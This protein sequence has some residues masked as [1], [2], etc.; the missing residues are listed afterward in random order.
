M[1]GT[2]VSR[3]R[4]P[5]A[6]RPLRLFSDDRLARM[7]A[8]G[9][10]RAVAALYERHHRA[11]FRYVLTIVRHKED[12][13]DVLQST[14]TNAITALR[15][16]TPDAPLRPWLFRIAHNEAISALRRRRP[17]AE[18]DETQA[19]A[20]GDGLER[21]LEDRRRLS[22]LVDDLG[23][24][25]ERQRSALVMRELSGLS[26]AE[27][28][29]AL[30]ISPAKAKQAILEARLSLRE[31]EKGRAMDCPDVRQVISAEDGRKLRGRT[32]RAHLRG[33]P[34]C[35]T[36][37]EAIRTREADLALLVPPLP[38]AVSAGLLAHLLG[39]SGGGGGG[40]AV[41]GK[42]AGATLFTKALAGVA[43]VATVGAGV[44]ATEIVVG[45]GGSDHAAKG[46]KTPALPVQANRRDAAASRPEV[47]SAEAA[48][49]ERK[50]QRRKGGSG[51]RARGGQP[52]VVRRDA[53]APAMLIVD[54]RS[55]RRPASGPAHPNRKNAHPVTPVKRR[56]RMSN[57]RPVPHPDPVKPPRIRKPH[58]ADPKPP[59][60]HSTPSVPAPPKA[61]G[62]N[63]PATP[64][65]TPAGR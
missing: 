24:L 50:S 14:M 60:P 40:G 61:N 10:Q 17:A 35:R 44:G 48:T 23:D 26:H 13:Q 6:R 22:L 1:S 28:A 55:S 33:C 20:L 32:V 42:V 34:D 29:G 31:F 54:A 38:A 43:V 18:F 9:D 58:K 16:G 56:R 53:Q 27:I 25:P 11:L 30:E 19:P 51:I 15:R 47:I 12:A 4:A 7:A 21:T 5:L 45:G 41:A 8:A 36:L 39:G 64:T 3:Q 2:A 65:P 49:P 63:V 52:R 59:K 37:R 57:A 46:R 62:P